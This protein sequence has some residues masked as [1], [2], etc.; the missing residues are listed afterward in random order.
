M[1]VSVVC[2]VAMVPVLLWSRGA[3]FVFEGVGLVVAL[4]RIVSDRDLYGAQVW[5][6]RRCSGIEFSDR[7]DHELKRRARDLAAL[8]RQHIGPNRPRF[9]APNT[10]TERHP[11][12]NS[13]RALSAR[14]N[15][16]RRVPPPV[17]LAGGGY[18]GALRHARRRT[19]SG[20][21]EPG[22]RDAQIAPKR[23][24]LGGG[25]A[26]SSSIG[27]VIARAHSNRSY[28]TRPKST[29]S[30][31]AQPEA[32][33]AAGASNAAA[34]AR[35]A[36]EPARKAVMTP[37]MPATVRKACS[38]Y[39]LRSPWTAKRDRRS[40]GMLSDVGRRPGAASR[41]E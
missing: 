16:P 28:L 24:Q 15:A 3:T 35:P 14:M 17:A 22:V 6:F 9:R 32:S 4:T 25:G 2:A 41:L 10:H 18:C 26:S 1:I 33:A 40:G 31:T 12:S 13:W 29:A 8:R 38:T 27:A 5:R 20:P 37:T 39:P 30:A 36:S 23:V 34:T 21:A 11:T 19:H 7:G